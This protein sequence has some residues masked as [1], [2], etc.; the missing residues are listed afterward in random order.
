MGLW[1]FLLGFFVVQHV[2]WWVWIILAFVGAS[3]AFRLE[4]IRLAPEQHQPGD[5]YAKPKD[6]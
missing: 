5:L 6:A 3:A 1:F 2:A 4:R